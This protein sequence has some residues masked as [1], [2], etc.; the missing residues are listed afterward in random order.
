MTWR[1]KQLTGL[2]QELR[3]RLKQESLPTKI[4]LSPGP[5]RQAYNLWLQDWE[6]WAMG[7][8]ID[9]LVVQNYAY[10]VKGFARDLDQPALRKAREWRIPTQIGILA[11]FGRRTT[12]MSVLRQR[13][14]L[15]RAKGH[16]VI[17]STGKGYGVNM[18]VQRVL[19]FA[20]MPFSNWV[21]R[22]SK[23]QSNINS[24]RC[25]TSVIGEGVMRNQCSEGI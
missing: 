3:T 24:K 23:H 7:E 15:A 18:Q 17:F 5:F 10:S 1:R 20:E 11:G 2:L 16:G 13:V 25:H 14:Q 12:P 8:L 21:L 19:R 9:E 4:S 22:T 6:L